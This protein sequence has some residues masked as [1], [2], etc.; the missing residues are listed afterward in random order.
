MN[1]LRA[2]R[3]R[4]A[5]ERWDRRSSLVFD[6]RTTTSHRIT[7]LASDLTDAERLLEFGDIASAALASNIS[8]L[9]IDLRQV[10]SADS[11]LVG[12]LLQLIRIARARRVRLRLY[13]S[14]AVDTWITV[15]RVDRFFARTS[16]GTDHSDSPDHMPAPV[17]P[18]LAC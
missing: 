4:R 14:A 6:E 15:C 2:R 18:R 10:N 17:F 1:P 5:L 8:T 13:I 11:K 12:L 3:E 9:I 16:V 7:C